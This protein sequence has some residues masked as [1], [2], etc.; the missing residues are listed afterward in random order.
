[1]INRR[2]DI[3]IMVLVIGVFAV[4]ALILLSFSSSSSGAKEKFVIIGMVSDVNSLVEQSNFYVKVGNTPLKMIPNLDGFAKEAKDNLP[5]YYE[6]SKNV[7]GKCVFREVYREKEL[8]GMKNKIVV[9]R[10]GNC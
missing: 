4:C 8:G 5:L 7:E 10:V 9:E 6:I 3:P 2:G 1:M